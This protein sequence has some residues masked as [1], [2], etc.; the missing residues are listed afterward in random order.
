MQKIMWDEGVEGR[1]GKLNDMVAIIGGAS[2]GMGAATAR[3][4]AREG[5]AVVVAARSAEKLDSLVEDITESGGTA[6]AVPTDANDRAAVAAMVESAREQFGRI[7][8]LVNSV[9]TNIKNRAL[10]R[11]V[12]RTGT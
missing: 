2:T 7:D 6:L 10:L 11:C 12:P 9:G 8:V 4:F 1:V 5:A 3:L